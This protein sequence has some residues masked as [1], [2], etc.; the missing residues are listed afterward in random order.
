MGLI[1]IFV[2]TEDDPEI[3]VV[4]SAP[5]EYHTIALRGGKTALVD[6]NQIRGRALMRAADIAANGMPAR[7]WDDIEWDNEER[8]GA[9]G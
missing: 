5:G 2:A 1:A 3:R 8:G 4:E 9:D 6:E 7:S